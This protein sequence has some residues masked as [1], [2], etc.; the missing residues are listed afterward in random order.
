VSRILFA[1][2]DVIESFLGKSWHWIL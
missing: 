2:T 1:K